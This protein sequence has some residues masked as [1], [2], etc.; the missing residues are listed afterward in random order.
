MNETIT[1][2]YIKKHENERSIQ[3]IMNVVND[4]YSEY[5]FEADGTVPENDIEI[6][7]QFRKYVVKHDSLTTF[8]DRMPKS[9][10]DLSDIILYCEKV[11]NQSAQPTL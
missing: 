8:K 3:F 10:K 6:A 5:L 4:L 11:V 2:D 9:N 7:G 1:L